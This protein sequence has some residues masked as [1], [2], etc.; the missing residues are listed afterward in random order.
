[1]S[2]AINY[3]Q[4]ITINKKFLIWTYAHPLLATIPGTTV[5]DEFYLSM[6]A[7][8]PDIN[9]NS[10]GG[11]YGE[12]FTSTDQL[13]SFNKAFDEMLGKHRINPTHQNE[14]L[15]LVRF[16]ASDMDQQS[17]NN[18]QHNRLVEYT[19]FILDITKNSEK[20]ISSYLKNKAY[21]VIHDPYTK[22]F[23]FAKHTLFDKYT[24]EEIVEYRP[25]D[26]PEDIVSYMRFMLG[27]TELYVPYD[28][29]FTL[30]G[31][32]D[33]KNFDG[34]TVA[35]FEIPGYLQ[36][37]LFRYTFEYMIEAH[38]TINTPF[39]NTIITAPLTS[40]DFKLLYKQYKKKSL[41]PN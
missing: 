9:V 10:F 37:E 26:N 6:W 35:Q 28:L 33:L 11:L 18:N 1:M 25:R 2:E 17:L 8:Q 16:Y 32:H 40:D 20:H 41:K 22:E 38:R 29:A 34:E 24:I 19:R 5:D 27:C 23:F 30:N 39:Y 31:S 14:L 7:N 13:I 15:Y 4:E 21:K 36:S 3:S 12:Q